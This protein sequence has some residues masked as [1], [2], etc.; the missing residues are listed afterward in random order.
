MKELGNRKEDNRDN[1]L[2][3]VKL[4]SNASMKEIIEALW[5]LPRDII[6]D[7]YD[8]ALKLLAKQIPMNIYEYP[9]GTECWSWIVPEKWTCHEAYLETLDGLRLFSYADNPLHVASYSCPVEGEFTREEL[10]KHLCTHSHIPEAV[11][12]KFLYYKRDWK[13]CCSEILKN[14][15]TDEKYRV[16]IKSEFSPGTLKVGEVIVHGES[17]DCIVL[18][19]HLCHPLQVNDGLS[20][21]VAGIEVFRELFERKNLRYTYRLLILPETIGSLA[22][23]SH[24]EE[25]IPDMKGGIFLEMLGLKNPH[26]LQLSFEGN[27]VFDKCCIAALREADPEGWTGKFLT[28]VTNDERQFNAPGVRVPMLSLS[29]VAKPN[30]YSSHSYPVLYPEYHSDYDSPEITSGES[31]KKSCDLVLRMIDTFEA[32][33]TPVNKFKGEIFCSRYGLSFDFDKD[34]EWSQAFCEIMILMDGTR[35]VL[36]IADACGISFSMAKS[37]IDKY[38]EHS[39]IEYKK[40]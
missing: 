12:F 23:L 4:S 20:G 39:A 9:T 32:N 27:T 22:Y 8:T 38:Y 11:P 29:R 14:K 5:K 2:F 30:N 28:I 21:V 17:K 13:L 36:E 16:V 26:A 1:Q 35:T 31:L 37:I 18:C 40:K 7:G 25:L 10:F 15:L 33:L 6:S 34:P 19:A 24:N 3:N